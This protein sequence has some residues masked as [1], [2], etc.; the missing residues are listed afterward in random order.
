MQALFDPTGFL[1]PVL[2]QGKVILRTS[3]EG[4]RKNIDWE[5]SLPKEV[6]EEIIQFFISLFKLEDDEFPR[7]L[8]PR[9]KTVGDPELVVFSDGSVKAFGA[10]V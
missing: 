10:V 9:Y 6:T 2:V 8:W 1:L 5:K 3:W 4:E 7:S